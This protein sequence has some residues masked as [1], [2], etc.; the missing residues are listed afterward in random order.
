MPALVARA[1]TF[2]A[3]RH[4]NF[5]LFIA[6]Q[7]V[8]LSGT[9]MQRVAEA[10]LVYQLTKSP[11]ALGIVG[12]ATRLPVIFLSLVAGV[13]A[14]RL[15]KRRILIV[16]QT[17]AM[18]QAFVLAALTFTGVVRFWHV[19]VLGT[20]LGVSESFDVPTRQSFYKDLVGGKDLMNAIALNS[21][22]FNLA[23]LTGPAV[24]GVLIA[25]TGVGGCFLVNALSYLAVIIAYLSM[26][27][28]AQDPRVSEEGHWNDLKE[29]LRYVRANPVISHAIALIGV[30]S[31]FAMSYS[32]L[33]PVFATEIL[34][35]GAGTYTGLMAAAGGGA[36]VA[37][38][39]VASLGNFQRKGLLAALGAIC[40]PL[41]VIAL[42]FARVPAAAYAVCV[43]LGTT[44][45]LLTASLNTLVQTAI[46]DR[47]RGRVMSLYVL[48]F[49]GCWP[50]GNLLAGRLAESLGV[51][52]TLRLGAGVSLAVSAALLL[53]TPELPR[54][55]S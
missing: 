20:L 39:T 19:A 24:A 38:L 26:R 42:S 15:D 18:C 27:L 34:K 7:A 6:G 32:T 41:A 48:V 9:W 36:L 29:G 1:N 23:R 55:K 43:T 12:F 30:A 8:S 17:V 37:A 4:R 35:G 44:M 5:R 49:F 28:R 10:W 2:S 45:I 13:L 47:L 16:T 11:L 25:S 3:L 52:A 40:F 50:L 53:K 22:I 31:L 33:L 14:D 46:T 54:F 51:I 21:T